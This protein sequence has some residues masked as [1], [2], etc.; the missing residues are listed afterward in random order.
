M[1]QEKLKIILLDYSILDEIEKYFKETSTQWLLT[2]EKF[3]DKISHF[4]SEIM[5]VNDFIQTFRF[6]FFQVF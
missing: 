4:N 1:K 2:E 3:F 5:Q 6:H